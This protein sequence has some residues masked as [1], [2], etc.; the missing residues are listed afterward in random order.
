MLYLGLRFILPWILGY[1]KTSMIDA[2]I[3]IPQLHFLLSA[4]QRYYF[5]LFLLYHS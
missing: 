1:L 4:I 2:Y 3:I 5:C